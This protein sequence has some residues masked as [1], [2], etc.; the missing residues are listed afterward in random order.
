MLN[1]FLKRIWPTESPVISVEII[2]EVNRSFSECREFIQNKIH[3]MK[4]PDWILING[5][6]NPI[7]IQNPYD[8]FPEVLESSRVLPMIIIVNMHTAEIKFYAAKWILRGYG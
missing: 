3:Q 2:P 4:G 7:C 1:R 5:F 6:A 8:L